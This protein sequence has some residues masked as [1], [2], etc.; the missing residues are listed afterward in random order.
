MNDDEL[1]EWYAFCALFDK[2]VANCAENGSAAKLSVNFGTKCV[3]VDVYRDK[4]DLRKLEE[5]ARGA[6]EKPQVKV[7]ENGGN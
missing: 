7:R 5:I 1:K 2:A 4:G 3:M 6:M